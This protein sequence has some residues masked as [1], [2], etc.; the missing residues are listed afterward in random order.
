MEY[1]PSTEEL[2]AVQ[3][4]REASEAEQAQSAPDEQETAQHQ[5]RADKARYL[6]EKL[7]QRAESERRQD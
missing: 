3:L 7:E 2:R 5:R 6:R 4:Q 1:E